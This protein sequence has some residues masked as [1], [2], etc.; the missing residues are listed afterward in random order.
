[1]IEF[2]NQIVATLGE[3][4]QSETPDDVDSDNGDESSEPEKTDE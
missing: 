2:K 1:M 4:A 3:E